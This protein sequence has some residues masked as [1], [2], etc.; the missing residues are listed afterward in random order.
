M[1][2]VG[3]SALYHESACCVLQ[4]GRLSAAAMEERFTRIKHDPRLPVHA[5]RY[6]L[7]AAGLTIADVDCIAWYELPQKKLARQLWSVG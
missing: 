1:N 3:I 6:C 7:A 4:D 2:I 5:F